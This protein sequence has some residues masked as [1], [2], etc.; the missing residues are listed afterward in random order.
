MFFHY[1]FHTETLLIRHL[2][3]QIRGNISLSNIW[4]KV[5]SDFRPGSIWDIIDNLFAQGKL[6]T[7][8]NGVISRVL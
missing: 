1:N 3:G 7:S 2:N 4:H 5:D 6:I 8:F